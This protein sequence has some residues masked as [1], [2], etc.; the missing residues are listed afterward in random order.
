MTIVF[1]TQIRF[2]R[3]RYP[4][5]VSAAS[6]VNRSVSAC[7]TYT[8]APGRSTVKALVN[9]SRSNSPRPS[10]PSFSMVSASFVLPT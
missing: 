1:F 8:G 7:A 5:R 9:A 2:C 4:A 3:T 10:A 6:N